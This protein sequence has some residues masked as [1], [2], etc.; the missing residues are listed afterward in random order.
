MPGI[1][2]TSNQDWGATCEIFIDGVRLSPDR[3]RY[4]LGLT[5]THERGKSDTLD[6]DFADPDYVLQNSIIRPNSTITVRCGWKHEVITKG[7]F[8]ILDY[9]PSFA[10]KAPGLSL[11]CANVA[12][13]KMNLNKRSASFKG[14]TAKDIFRKIASDYGL[15]PAFRIKPEDD[16]VFTDEKSFTAPSIS[17]R[18]LLNKLCDR[19]GGYVW[20]VTDTILWVQ[21]PED[22]G[23]KIVLDY[24]IQNKTIKSFTPE[25]KVLVRGNGKKSRKTVNNVDIFNAEDVLSY[26][27]ED[28][29][30]G[31]N[32]SETEGDPE[33]VESPLSEYIKLENPFSFATEPDAAPATKVQRTLSP[34]DLKKQNYYGVEVIKGGLFKFSNISPAQQVQGDSQQ[35]TAT[36]SDTAQKQLV[37]SAR[38]TVVSGGSLIPTFPSFA[39]NGREVVYLRGLSTLCNGRYEVTKATLK[40]DNS[41]GLQTELELSTRVPGKGPGKQKKTS[42][43]AS[44]ELA[45]AGRT[46][47]GVKRNGVIVNPWDGQFGRFQTQHPNESDAERQEINDTLDFMFKNTRAFRQ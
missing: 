39:W 36:D 33:Y 11:S 2:P 5:V 15:I 47:A 32:F 43:E 21:Q 8:K 9:K 44:S 22:D 31:E 13:T 40:Y 29:T 7:P 38:R 45:T 35:A 41:K 28:M 30:F 34:E 42:E 17:D 3:M 27:A 10:D 24:R 18:T 14:L 46:V 25:I 4:F 20:G 37:K 1:F 6:I 12:A 23:E 16:L 26:K 19:M